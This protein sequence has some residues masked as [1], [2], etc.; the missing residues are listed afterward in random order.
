MSGDI[1]ISEHANKQ[2]LIRDIPRYRILL[3]VLKP[4]KIKES[5]R[6]GKL[7]QKRFRNKILEVVTVIEDQSTIVITQYYL[8]KDI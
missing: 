8:D 2:R 1:V 4:D 3:A 5:F 7:Y 6:K